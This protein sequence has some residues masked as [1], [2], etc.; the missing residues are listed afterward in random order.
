MSCKKFSQYTKYMLMCMLGCS[1]VA[2]A[3]VNTEYFIDHAIIQFGK[4][5]TVSYSFPT[6]KYVIQC[7]SDQPGSHLGSIAWQYNSYAFTVQ[8]GDMRRL[9][10]STDNPDVV[11]AYQQIADSRGSLVIANLDNSAD[12]EISCRYHLPGSDELHTK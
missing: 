6:N 10:L 9:T 11:Y 8:M 2:L 5:L 12:L 1:S 7:A 3:D 4:P